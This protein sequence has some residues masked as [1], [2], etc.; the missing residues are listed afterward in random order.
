MRVRDAR[1]MR[2][3]FG[4]AAVVGGGVVAWW[5]C[6]DIGGLRGWLDD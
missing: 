3:G 5:E 1:V 2:E 4:G 6:C